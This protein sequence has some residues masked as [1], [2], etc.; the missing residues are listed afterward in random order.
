MLCCQSQ[1]FI[2]PKTI[3]S[4]D[5]W[6]PKAPNLQHS[7]HQLT[8]PIAFHQW[9]KKKRGKHN[10]TN[11]EADCDMSTAPCKLQTSCWLL[12]S[13]TIQTQHRFSTTSP[14]SQAAAM[15]TASKKRRRSRNLFWSR[16]KKTASLQVLRAECVT[17]DKSLTHSQNPPTA[18]HHLPTAA[19]FPAAHY[20]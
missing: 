11:S 5:S 15:H 6:K 9:S 14:W 7:S 19:S 17:A 1:W 12:P 10:K 13:S 20:P 18:E 4:S 2:R 8:L 3:Q 16:E